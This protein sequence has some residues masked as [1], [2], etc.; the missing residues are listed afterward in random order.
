MS[1][2]ELQT[3]VAHSDEKYQCEEMSDC[4]Y[5]GTT[6]INREPWGDWPADLDSDSIVIE[7]GDTKEEEGGKTKI[8]TRKA[9]LLNKMKRLFRK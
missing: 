8:I 9:G 7:A 1:T 3:A 2:R 6:V 4:P 5:T